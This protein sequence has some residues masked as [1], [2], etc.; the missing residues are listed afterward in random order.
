VLM[1]ALTRISEMFF[2]LL[3]HSS[4]VVRLFSILLVSGSMSA[5]CVIFNALLSSRFM[6]LVLGERVSL[7]TIGVGL[8]LCDVVWF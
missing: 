6:P 4:G 7:N 8:L 3:I 5:C 1:V 2:G